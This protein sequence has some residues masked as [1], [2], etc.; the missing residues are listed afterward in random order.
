[1]R[2]LS[3]RIMPQTTLARNLKLSSASPP[4]KS[5]AVR[6]ASKLSPAVLKAKQS[7]TQGRF[8]GKPSTME[9][10]IR[11]LGLDPV[12]FLGPELGRGGL[13]W[14]SGNKN[15]GAG[16]EET[17][18]AKGETGVMDEDRTEI[19]GH[20]ANKQAER[21]AEDIALDD[22]DDEVVVVDATE[23]KVKNTLLRGTPVGKKDSTSIAPT[24]EDVHPCDP[25][26][27]KAAAA[28][29]HESDASFLA[30]TTVSHAGSSNALKRKHE[31]R[32]V[33]DGGLEGGE[34]V[35]GAHE[36]RGKKRA[37]AD[38]EGGVAG[39]EGKCA[40]DA[41]R[42]SKK[43][44]DAYEIHAKVAHPQNAARVDANPPLDQL[45]QLQREL[46]GNI[47]P[48]RTAESSVKKKPSSAN[49]RTKGSAAA[50]KPEVLET[51]QEAGT[52]GIVEKGEVVVYWMRMEDMRGTF[53][54]LPAFTSFLT[55]YA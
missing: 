49:S 18:G 48:S 37:P 23:E 21:A 52:G 41:G 32:E 2:L 50:G 14:I 51:G 9:D 10:D 35:T 33:A 3:A 22:D 13:A 38:G 6:N 36:G 28:V 5:T 20:Q 7:G 45:L 55:S 46:W 19:D 54:T 26:H 29:Q 1:M 4:K 30:N 17:K 39:A 8:P 47:A 43:K 24:E 25:D 42:V 44:K 40:D 16:K 11:A 27:Q 34:N 31:K 12:Q 15:S 53:S